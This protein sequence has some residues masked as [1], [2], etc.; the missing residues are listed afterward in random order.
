MKPLYI[1]GHLD[2]KP[3]NRMLGD[4]GACVNIIPYVV[5]KKLGHSE[6]DLM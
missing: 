5:F 2:G 3:M 1:K 4:R 6:A